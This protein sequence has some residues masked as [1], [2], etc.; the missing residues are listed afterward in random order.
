MQPSFPLWMTPLVVSESIV[1][2]VLALLVFQ[3]TARKSAPEL[4]VPSAVFV[5]LWLLL[6]FT[7]SM[8]GF[9]SRASADV[10]P[11][12]AYSL[13]PLAIGY[14]AFLTM[15]SAR[16]VV[17]EIPLHWMIGMQLYRAV[18]VVF[19]V[20]WMLGAMPGA[21]ALPAGI[22]DVGI[23]LAAPLVASLVKRRAPNARVAAIV[24]NVL[25]IADLSV[26]V[27]MGVLTSPGPLHRLAFDT[28]NVAITM[29][30]LVLVPTIAVPFSLLAHLLTLHR[31]AGREQPSVLAIS[32]AA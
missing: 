15:R 3:R 13:L 16:M 12:I 23:G 31:L 7:L 6:A 5:G 8:R 27:T 18:G 20:E 28:P 11:P 30:P 10:V 32:K 29:M 17:E 14:L 24:W 9:F 1:I 21:F 19:L 25:G 22:G 26:A 2:P 4:I